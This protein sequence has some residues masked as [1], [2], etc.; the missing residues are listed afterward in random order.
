MV[1]YRYV[2]VRMTGP[3][4]SGNNVMNLKKVEF[5][6]LLRKGGPGQFSTARK[7]KE[8]K[9]PAPAPKS[10]VSSEA[11]S[12]EAVGWPNRGAPAAFAPP[13][14]GTTSGGST[15][16]QCG[17]VKSNLASQAKTNVF[18]SGGG[19]VG[20]VWGPSR[21]GTPSNSGGFRGSGK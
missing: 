8:E 20:S 4:N 5:F 18:G 1:M 10:T 11:K 14:S 13:S 17:F 7:P 16:S 12:A 21:T 19:S 3:N 9:A 15:F 2:R 6:G